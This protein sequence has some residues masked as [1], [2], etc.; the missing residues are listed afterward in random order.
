MKNPAAGRPGRGRLDASSRGPAVRQV[1][2]S[3]A[4]AETETGE[5]EAQQG[6]RRGLRDRPGLAVEEVVEGDHIRYP[7]TK[8]RTAHVPSPL[9]DRL[10]RAAV[11]RAPARE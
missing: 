1:S 10:R 11:G 7:A 8:L 2:V 5:A 3:P 9:S 4:A 6:Q